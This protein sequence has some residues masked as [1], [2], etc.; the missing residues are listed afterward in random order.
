MG[1]EG[2]RLLSLLIGVL[3]G[4]P[5]PCVTYMLHFHRMGTPSGA[6]NR[7]KKNSNGYPTPPFERTKIRVQA[8]AAPCEGKPLGSVFFFRW[9]VPP[10]CTAISRGGCECVYNRRLQ[11]LPQVENSES[12]SA[13]KS[14]ECE[15]RISNPR[16]MLI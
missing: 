1:T 2:L 16:G 9:S 8:H 12:A 6:A 4:M 7:S 5:I 15:R 11:Q 13:K 14:S 3:F 10:H